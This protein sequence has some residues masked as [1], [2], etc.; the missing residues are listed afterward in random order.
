MKRII[1]FLIYFYVF[2]ATTNNFCNTI[3]TQQRQIPI[4]QTQKNIISFAKRHIKELNQ[5]NSSADLLI[6]EALA[7]QLGKKYSNGKQFDQNLLLES[8]K[9]KQ[10]IN[11]VSRSF[12]I[13][14]TNLL[15]NLKL[16]RKI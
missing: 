9:L 1:I 4:T 2:L 16:I 6:A 8:S 11:S 7:L 10:Q 3:L 15:N 14:I 12:K 5:L 13:N